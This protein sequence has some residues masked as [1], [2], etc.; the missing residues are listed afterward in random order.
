MNKKFISTKLIQDPPESY[1][2][3]E[4]YNKKRNIELKKDIPNIKYDKFDELINLFEQYQQN[5]KNNKFIKLIST[6]IEK[7]FFDIKGVLHKYEFNDLAIKALSPFLLNLNKYNLS[8][9]LYNLTSKENEDQLCTNIVV[10]NINEQTYSDIN[11][12]LND[13]KNP[14][15][16]I[17]NLEAE[18][19]TD[20]NNKIYLAFK[21]T[22]K[23]KIYIEVK[24]YI[25]YID[26]IQL[27]EFAY[28][29]GINTSRLF[30]EINNKI[31][32]FKDCVIDT[33]IKKYLEIE[34]ESSFVEYCKD[35]ISHYYSLK[36][37]KINICCYVKNI[38]EDKDKKLMN[39]TLENL[40]DLNYIILEIPKNS[41]FLDKLFKNCIYIFFNLIL[42]V[43]EKL[44]VKLTVHRKDNITS[45]KFLF[46]YLF[47]VNKYN[48]KKTNDI[49]YNN[50]Y[51]F[52]QFILLVKYNKIIRTIQKYLVI[53]HQ[54]YFINL[55]F[56]DNI[57]NNYEGLILCSDGT[58]KAML[59]IKGNDISELKKFK[60]DVNSMYYLSA[61]KKKY[62]KITL[63]PKFNDNIQLIA[64]GN[65]FM[66]Y[67]R[68]LT[69]FEF[70]EN[71]K[72]LSKNKNMNSFDLLITQNEFTLI[73]GAFINNKKYLEV[74]PM[75]K[76]LKVIDLEE[77]SNSNKFITKSFTF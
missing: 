51:K 34:A 11:N 67:G 70:Y 75:I 14:T 49:L 71:I 72:D 6:N 54:I 17:T 41:K 59:F 63:K 47:D 48:I 24:K 31:L 10:S 56:S 61:K 22:Y 50:K 77:Y 73:N 5:K 37:N 57:I 68:N 18:L 20:L 69:F 40:F 55:Y 45:K 66:G 16:I 52:N 12:N 60:I 43:D 13:H 1:L 28:V 2:D 30:N 64:I 29:D 25:E 19:K 4:D 26:I 8:L 42:F 33:D 65:P 3:L 46:Y 74:I 7:N 58:S 62:G 15:L 32:K 38:Y 53:I 76:V 39:V 27:N 21:N 36:N 9:D 44:N 35:E 23:T